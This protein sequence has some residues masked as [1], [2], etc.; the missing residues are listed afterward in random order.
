MANE[1]IWNIFKIVVKSGINE[2]SWK[3]MIKR[4]RIVRRTL[5]GA[6]SGF[7]AT[8]PMTVTMFGIRK[9]LPIFHRHSV[10][11]YRITTRVFRKLRM[12]APWET[13]RKKRLPLRHILDTA[14]QAVS[15]IPH[16]QTKVISLPQLRDHYLDL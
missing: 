15:F 3:N 8:F 14:R 12:L 9:A 10:P 6:A 7:L 13:K 11:P 1:S 2:L 16:L 5:N 4:K